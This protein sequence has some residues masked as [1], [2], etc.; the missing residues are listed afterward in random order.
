MALRRSE[1]ARAPADPRAAPLPSVHRTPAPAPMSIVPQP[2]P[3]AAAVKKRRARRNAGEAP[4]PSNPAHVTSARLD[5]GRR[6]ADEPDMEPALLPPATAAAAATNVTALGMGNAMEFNVVEVNTV[7]VDPPV[8][9][10]SIPEVV[11]VDA[12]MAMPSP[13]RPRPRPVG[14]HDL[15]YQTYSDDHMAKLVTD[16]GG[17]AFVP[18]THY[19]AHFAQRTERR[20]LLA[21]EPVFPVGV[22]VAPDD[23]YM[24]PSGMMT[25]MSWSG[26][27]GAGS[28]PPENNQ[29]PSTVLLY[30]WSRNGPQTYIAPN[31]SIHQNTFPGSD[32]AYAEDILA[33]L[34]SMPDSMAD[35]AVRECMA[36]DADEHWCVAT[37]RVV[38]DFQTQGWR[39]LEGQGSFKELE[40]LRAYRIRRELPFEL[41]SAVVPVE[42]TGAA[43]FLK[44]WQKSTGMNLEGP[45]LSWQ[46]TFIVALKPA[47]KTVVPAVVHATSPAPAVVRAPRAASTAPRAAEDIVPP[48]VAAYFA[49]HIRLEE[50]EFFRTLFEDSHSAVYRAVLTVRRVQ[51]LCSTLGL[52]WP[53]KGLNGAMTVSGLQVSIKQLV[54]WLKICVS[55][56]PK[57]SMFGNHRTWERGLQRV[58]TSLQTR[59]TLMSEEKDDLAACKCLLQAEFTRCKTMMG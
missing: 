35:L 51:F 13:V 49:L 7:E 58:L 50:V 3:A 33:T 14:H 40:P 52:P 32:E 37:A 43:R 27:A 11:D 23:I 38:I 8:V 59:R 4:A 22:S 9:A 28:P 44:K 10:P 26:W 25:R 46:A 18:P 56:C 41:H 2:A 34:R 42:A 36:S 30:I 29:P 1:R 39:G 45:D 48:E 31:L 54:L 12:M 20:A 15:L 53:Q 47:P 5:S 57:L 24:S 55:E 16:V 21:P 19:E 6:L 17:A